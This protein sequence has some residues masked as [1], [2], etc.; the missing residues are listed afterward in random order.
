M[1]I[2]KQGSGVGLGMEPRLFDCEA[3]S[4]TVECS[5]SGEDDPYSLGS[6]VNSTADM[7]VTFLGSS[8]TRWYSKMVLRRDSETEAEPIIKSISR[9]EAFEAFTWSLTGGQEIAASGSGSRGAA[10]EGRK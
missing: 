2:P 3:L 5:P 8:S 7:L 1:A 9:P 6:G 10:T 4:R